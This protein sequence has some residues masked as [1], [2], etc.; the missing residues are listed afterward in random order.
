VLGV[1]ESGELQVEFFRRGDRVAHR[2]LHRGI[3]LAESVEGT[4]DEDWPPSPP[5][6]E[7]H[8]E[9]SKLPGRDEPCPIA[10]LVGM[11]GRSH[12]SA[13]VVPSLPEEVTWDTACRLHGPPAW[14]GAQYR[15]AAPVSVE[16]HRGGNDLLQLRLDVSPSIGLTIATAG[17]CALQC[18]LQGDRLAIA[19]PSAAGRFPMT[20]QLA[21]RIGVTPGATR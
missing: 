13:S 4:P 10:L 19:F 6:Q 12:W 15:F 7:V 8:F 18:E 21:Y 2:L 3:L 16:A 14:L 1:I 5:F 9:S 11:A 20:A 17:Q